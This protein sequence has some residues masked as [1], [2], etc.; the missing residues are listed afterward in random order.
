VQNNHESDATHQD[1]PNWT[2]SCSNDFPVREMIGASSSVESPR[3]ADAQASDL[4]GVAASGPNR[5][6]STRRALDA[7]IRVYGSNLSGNSFYEDARTINVSVHG[8]LLVLNVPVSKGQKLLLFNEGTQRQQVCQ[9]VDIRVR[10]TESHDVAVA[11]PVPHAEFW[12]VFP[13]RHWM[14]LHSKI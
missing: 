6:R 1:G 5:R 3:Q 7:V 12:H 4:G 2:N 14:Q 10:D 13:T 9:I 11:F 8:A